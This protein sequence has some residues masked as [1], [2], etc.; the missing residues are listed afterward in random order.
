VETN[1]VL[2]EGG[3]TR[4]GNDQENGV[5]GGQA[6]NSIGDVTYNGGNGGNGNEGDADGGGGG[7]A[8]GSTGPGLNGVTVT[9]GGPTTLYGGFGGNGGADGDYGDPGGMYG[10]GGG[11]SSAQGSQDRNGGPGHSG[12]VMVSWVEVT[13]F[14]PTVLCAGAQDNI[15][16]TGSNFTNVDSVTVNGTPVTYS[17]D[18]GVQ[19]TIVNLGS[20]TTGDIIVY[21]DHGSAITSAALTITNNSVNVTADNS[22]TVLT[23]NYTGGPGETYQ[24]IDCINSNDPIS[25]AVDS[26]FTA[27]SNG[28]YAVIVSENG[29]D[30][31]SS[32]FTV[33]SVRLIEEAS[34]DLDIF[35]NPAVES[36]TISTGN[37]I[38]DQLRI[39]NL[40]AQTVFEDVPNSSTAEINVEDLPSGVYLIEVI[41]NQLVITKKLI[42]TK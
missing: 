9:G 28:L 34:N 7:S 11:G 20:A 39:V 26:T 31:Q 14:T 13:G 38:M 16:I 22:G 37:A 4:T 42:K 17:V 35:P 15:I 5:P 18:S 2:A 27:S 40:N 23:A 24:W 19:I 21:T 33:A 30:V 36:I 12:L 10:G 29:C 3:M 41:S 6:A 1:V 25:G 32:C 8:A